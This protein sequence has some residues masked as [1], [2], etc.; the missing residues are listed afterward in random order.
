MFGKGASKAE[1]E[2]IVKSSTM[3]GKGTVIEGNIETL[4][5]ISVDGKLIGNIKCKSKVIVGQSAEI[6]GNLHS[7][8]AEIAGHVK[9]LVEIS[10][11][12][13]LK[14]TAVIDGDINASKL[15]VEEGAVING[16]CKMGAIVKDFKN[17]ENIT[18]NGTGTG[19]RKKEK[20][21]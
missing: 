2:E 5:S 20:T 10:D 12:L 17:E 15:K 21:A 8:N 13:I 19:E 9:G 1:M 16:N 14:P 11:L 3:I 4:G 6:E 18:S 7:Q